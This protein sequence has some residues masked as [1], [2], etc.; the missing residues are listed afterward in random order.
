M[1]SAFK[2]NNIRRFSRADNRFHH[3]HIYY[4]RNETMMS[5]WESLKM[6][7]QVI[8]TVVDASMPLEKIISLHP[9]IVQAL[10]EQQHQEASRHLKTHYAVIGNYWKEK[11]D[12][13]V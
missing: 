9:P 2:D 1:I 10:R 8:A 13:A 6:Q 4:T 7:L 12:K 5:I 3:A 11:K